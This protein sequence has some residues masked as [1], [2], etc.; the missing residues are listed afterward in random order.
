MER[1]VPI[2]STETGG[3]SGTSRR[4]FRPP[5]GIPVKDFEQKDGVFSLEAAWMVGWQSLEGRGTLGSPKLWPLLGCEWDQ[6]G[7]DG[8]ESSETGA[9]EKARRERLVWQA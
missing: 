2:Q 7:P 1:W 3:V 4:G 8:W 9:G 6:G 5:S